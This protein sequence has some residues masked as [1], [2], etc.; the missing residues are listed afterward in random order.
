ME[1]PAAASSYTVIQF[2]LETEKNGAPRQRMKNWG[3]HASVEA[4]FT[5]ARCLANRAWSTLRD[6]GTSPQETPSLVDTEWGYDVRLGPLT[7]QRFWVHENVT[8]S[9][10]A[11]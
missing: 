4:A 5:N 6:G 11:P 10:R 8:S 7:V 1:N 3:A 9:Q 2:S